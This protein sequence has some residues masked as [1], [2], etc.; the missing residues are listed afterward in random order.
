MTTATED[1]YTIKNPVFRKGRS[2]DSL[3]VVV[4]KTPA[5]KDKSVH[6]TLR[7]V[8]N[9]NFG[10]GYMGYTDAVSYT[11]LDV[12]KRQVVTGYMNIRNSS[13]TGN[14]V[15]VKKEDLL[16][17]SKT[18]VIKA[19]Q[20][21][22][23]SFRIKENNRW[24]SDPNALPEVYIRGESGL[25]VR[26]L[27]A[28]ALDVYKRQ[29]SKEA[30]KGLNTVLIS[31]VTEFRDM[32]DVERQNMKGAVLNAVLATPVAAYAEELAAFYQTTRS[33]YTENLYGCAGWY[34]YNRYGFSDPRTVGFLK[35]PN[36]YDY[37]NMPTETQ[38][39]GMYIRCV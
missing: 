23:P 32:S 4:H 1:Q 15:T 17:V 13:F 24:G 37:S 16:K 34:F 29:T 18:N 36:P 5:L 22:D 6:L 31:R 25:G 11:H 2:S 27:D 38:D 12:Y 3:S 10:L 39:V 21:F 14:A 8:E 26:Q 28:D 19:L 33:C 7:L 30:F 9:E 35:E 20:A